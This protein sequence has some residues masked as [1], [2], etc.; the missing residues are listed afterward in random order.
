M[1]GG[2]LTASTAISTEQFIIKWGLYTIPYLALVTSTL[3]PYG[4]VTPRVFLFRAIV[5]ILFVIY[6]VGMMRG[7]VSPTRSLFGIPILAYAVF[8]VVLAVTTL[9]GVNPARSM[10]G[11]IERMDGVFQSFH[12]LMFLLLMVL[13]F[14][15]EDDWLWFFRIS[16]GVSLVVAMFGISEWVS[17]GP[18]HRP[19]STIGNAG[20]LGEYLLVHV[21]LGIFLAARDAKLR[22]GAYLAVAIVELIALLLTGTR[23]GALG[24]VF[25]LIVI[26]GLRVMFPKEHRTA[27]RLRVAVVS[28]GSL[29]VVVAGTWGIGQVG[30]MSGMTAPIRRLMTLIND[31]AANRLYAWKISLR[32]IW[33]KPVLGWGPNNF[34]RAFNQF[35]QPRSDLTTP[36][37]ED[38]WDRTHNIILDLGISSGVVG[39]IAFVLLLS[40]VIWA[41]YRT[42]HTTD[43]PKL[44]GPMIVMIGLVLGYFVNLL[45]IFPVLTTSILFVSVVGYANYYWTQSTSD[46]HQ[47]K[48]FAK[49]YSKPVRVS[50]GCIVAVT[51]LALYNWTIIPVDR[52]YRFTLALPTSSTVVNQAAIDRIRTT[53]NNQPF[54]QRELRF[55]VA[56]MAMNTSGNSNISRFIQHSLLN[57]A[58]MELGLQVALDHEDLR[59]F[60]DLADVLYQRALAD[61]ALAEAAADAYQRAI[62][63]S[64]KQPQLYMGLADSFIL[65]EDLESAERALQQVVSYV[66]R[67][68][69]PRIT[70][71]MIYIITKQEQ[72]LSLAQKALEELIREQR[73]SLTYTANEAQRLASAYYGTEDPDMA[74][75]IL[76][77]QMEMD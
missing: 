34:D 66:P 46:S 77:H 22:R 5:E 61:P 69:E 32:A 40:I 60:W 35:F 36:P 75:Q 14:S 17:A 8:V 43:A 51:I 28:L 24:L 2:S 72:Q 37:H 56:H 54:D 63:V 59:P 65:G 1:R 9:T 71:V 20:Y 73:G 70:L 12:H 4:F 38:W 44:Q 7:R 39:V 48:L 23:A 55:M 15:K 27:V 52:L 18:S 33:D 25:G 57:L 16:L 31:T 30:F 45:F 21:F 53:L 10:W 42:A 62:R 13:V 19:I 68:V 29:S 6:L 3:L 41:F 76:N 11:G 67:W 50:I 74:T 47:T 64:P 26:G 49:P 58:A